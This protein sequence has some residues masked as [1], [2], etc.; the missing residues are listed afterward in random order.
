MT[1]H[2]TETGAS[3]SI[4]AVIGS[5]AILVVIGGIFLVQGGSDPEPRS[6]S[7]D[8][9]T[10]A[11]TTLSEEPSQDA[12]A[13]EKADDAWLAQARAAAKDGY[14]AF[15]PADVPAGWTVTDA[16][17]APDTSWHLGL[18]A[19]SGNTVSIDQHSEGKVPDLV[20]D[21]IGSADRDGKVNLR[22]WGTGVWQTWTSEGMVALA[23]ELAGTVVVV[24]GA[25]DKAEVVEIT[26]QLL[27]AEM[28]VNVGDGS[29]G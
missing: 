2:R 27:T 14:P 12:S 3:T 6:D 4:G 13:S 9:P 18:T 24:S 15:V 17:Y 26:K 8:Q 19:P 29:D 16:A 20:S 1:R 21:L 25:T 10:A 23:Q 7:T 22:R 28:V 5:L 11:V